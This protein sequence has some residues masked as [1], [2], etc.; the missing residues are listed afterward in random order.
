PH[1][2]SPGLAARRRE[3]GR[4]APAAVVVVSRSL[5]LDL[6]APLFSAA[7]TPTVVL[8]CAA[9]PRPRRRAAA[10]VGRVVVAGT[11]LVDLKEGVRRL[12]DGLGL[13][14]LVCEG[15][16]TLNGP[17]LSAGLVD[18]LC[19]TLTP[20]LLGDGGP[21]LARGLGRR[22]PLELVGLAEQD[23][24]LFARYRLAPLPRGVSNH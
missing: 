6:D 17:L 4:P 23:G 9:S 7:V 24:D 13:A 12:R 22:L 20:A 16:P 8:T 10:R 3:D 15:G 19:L 11:D 18:E 14:H 1:R 2:P 21:R 5:D